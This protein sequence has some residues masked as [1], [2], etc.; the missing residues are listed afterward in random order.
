MVLNQLQQDVEYGV[1]QRVAPAMFMPSRIMGKVDRRRG[2]MNYYD[3][4]LLG[5]QTL[6]QAV[7]AMPAGGDVGIGKD[8]MQMLAQWIEDDFMIDWMKLPEHGGMT[9]TEVNDR[10]QLRA[11]GLTGAL[12]TIE[13]EL[14]GVLGDRTLAVM[15]EENMVG[16][17]PEALQGVGVDWDYA[18]PLAMA[19]QQA[20]VDSVQRLFELNQ[21]ARAGAQDDFIDVVV[22]DE[23]L[24]LAA[25]SLGLP[26]AI[27]ETMEA[28]AQA[29]AQQAQQKQEQ[30][31]AQNA[32][33]GAA[34][35]QS[36]AQG[37]AALQGAAT[38]GAA[39]NIRSPQMQMA[40]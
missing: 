17:P 33:T 21:M 1:G 39:N 20:M 25:N 11:V 29:K 18:G 37:L 10:K 12:G 4:K 14:M 32:Q 34:A 7:Q 36:G 6:Q 16:V 22:F 9:A 8:Y 38:A 26:P 35:F 40:A 24:R 27:I 3:P 13:R 15:T 5:F 23:G 30:A 19:Q 31:E 28:V 2:A